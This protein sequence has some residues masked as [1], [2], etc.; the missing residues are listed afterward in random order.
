MADLF[1]EL[2]DSSTRVS[3]LYAKHAG[4]IK[5]DF[6]NFFQLY[7][8]EV[9]AV[10]LVAVPKSLRSQPAKTSCTTSTPRGSMHFTLRKKSSLKRERCRTGS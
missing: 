9:E 4:M 3:E 2:Q 7:K 1:N 6:S 8:D 10:K 5:N